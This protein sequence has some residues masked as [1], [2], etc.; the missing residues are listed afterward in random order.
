[1]KKNSMNLRTFFIG[2][3]NTESMN[4]KGLTILIVDDN[5]DNCLLLKELLKESQANILIAETG[6]EANIIVKREE[7]HLVLMDYKLPDIN[8]FESAALI[9][10][11]NKNIPVILQTA[12][13]REFKNDYLISSFMDAILAQPVHKYELFHTINKCLKKYNILKNVS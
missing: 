2:T 11:I 12:Y 4:L 1:M 9:K 5:K 7:V 10:K 6:L 8:G 13:Y 3:T